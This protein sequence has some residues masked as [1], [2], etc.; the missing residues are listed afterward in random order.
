MPG[1]QTAPVGDRKNGETTGQTLGKGTRKRSTSGAISNAKTFQQAQA[2]T[3]F[4]LRLAEL[5]TKRKALRRALSLL[6]SFS[7]GQ[8][9]WATACLEQ[10]ACWLPWAQPVASCQLRAEHQPLAARTDREGTERARPRLIL[11]I[12]RVPLRGFKHLWA[13]SPGTFLLPDL[14]C[15]WWREK[16][17]KSEGKTVMGKLLQIP[18][19]L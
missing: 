19:I 1:L 10:A 13:G 15:W 7:P 5:S 16:K 12:L 6:V 4:P 17:K 18:L 11:C 3:Q 8:R 9:L 14:A 2:Q